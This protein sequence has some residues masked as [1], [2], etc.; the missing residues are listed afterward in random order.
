MRCKACGCYVPKGSKWKKRAKKH[1]KLLLKYKKK[2]K[3]L[4]RH[5]E[6]VSIYKSCHKKKGW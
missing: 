2:A 1:L 6:T 5:L 3:I 4:K